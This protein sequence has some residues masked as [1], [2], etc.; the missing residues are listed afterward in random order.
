MGCVEGLRM[1]KMPNRKLILS[2]TTVRKVTE[3]PA[4]RLREIGGG[5]RNDPICSCAAHCSPE[6]QKYCP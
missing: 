5:M 2:R 6:S 3:L 4:E 1:N